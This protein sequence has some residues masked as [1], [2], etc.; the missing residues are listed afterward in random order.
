MCVSYILSSLPYIHYNLEYFY[1]IRI[2]YNI[3]NDK[4]ARF[5]SILYID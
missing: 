4:Q 2:A 3:A 1:V 5:T